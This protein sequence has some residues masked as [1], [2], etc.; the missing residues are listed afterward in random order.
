M[1]MKFATT[2]AEWLYAH[3]RDAGYNYLHL[4]EG[5][6]FARGEYTTTTERIPHG[7]SRFPTALRGFGLR[8][9]AL[10]LLSKWQMPRGFR[11]KLI[12]FVTTNRH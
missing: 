7:W 10:R 6:N 3:L 2:N 1:G 9:D 11:Q 12:T 8:L 5:Y 4:D